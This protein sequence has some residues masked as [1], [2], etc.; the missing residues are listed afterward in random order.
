[1]VNGRGVKKGRNGEKRK[2]EG[3]KV[4][5]RAIE[6]RPLQGED[7]T[8]CFCF[9]PDTLEQTA[10]EARTRRVRYT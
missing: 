8:R 6:G 10:K 4:E 3:N 7:V 9:P 1:M 2:R 5:K